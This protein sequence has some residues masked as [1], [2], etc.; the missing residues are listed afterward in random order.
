MADID[1]LNNVDNSVDLRISVA[2]ISKIEQIKADFEKAKEWEAKIDGENQKILANREA[3]AKKILDGLFNQTDVTIDMKMINVGT[4]MAVSKGVDGMK[5]WI[6]RF[7]E[8]L[9]KH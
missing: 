3:E 6:T 7:K 8:T 1:Q 4:F 9:E 2:E 5:K